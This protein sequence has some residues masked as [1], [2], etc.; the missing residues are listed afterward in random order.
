[1][2]MGAVACLSCKKNHATTR[3][4]SL[5]G[6]VYKG[7]EAWELF[8]GADSGDPL[9]NCI[10]CTDFHAFSAHYHYAP[11]FD[12]DCGKLQLTSISETI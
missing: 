8:P 9:T 10:V 6:G 4:L 7:K 5:S 2:R 12:Q 11:T 3:L 1:M